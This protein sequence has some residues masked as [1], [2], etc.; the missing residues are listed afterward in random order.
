V[1]QVN[2]AAMRKRIR[3]TLGKNCTEFL[4]REVGARSVMF[5]TMRP[6]NSEPAKA[7]RR[8]DV[9]A[10]VEAPETACKSFFNST[11]TIGMHELPSIQKTNTAK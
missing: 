3:L 2:C 1:L 8:D 5:L 10:S 7:P 11:A 9:S 4:K 6:E